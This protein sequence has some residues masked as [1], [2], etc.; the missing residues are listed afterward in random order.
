VKLNAPLELLEIAGFVAALEPINALADAAPG[1]V[2]RLKGD[3]GDATSIR[4]LADDQ[5]LLNMSVGVDRSLCTSLRAVTE[6]FCVGAEWAD[7]YAGVQSTLRWI[8][9]GTVPDASEA[10]ARLDALERLRPTEYAFT[11]ASPF[12]ALLDE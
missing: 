6:K 8:V 5:V 11:F 2:W 4:V 9:A 1:F 12:N 3:E 7:R 10:V